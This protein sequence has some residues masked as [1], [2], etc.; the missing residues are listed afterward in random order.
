MNEPKRRRHEILLVLAGLALG[1]DKNEQNRRSLRILL[2]LFGLVLL[3]YVL[4]FFWA[5]VYGLMTV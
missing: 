5:L 4:W 2:L 3:G 1:R